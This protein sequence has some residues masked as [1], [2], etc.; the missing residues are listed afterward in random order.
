MRPRAGEAHLQKGQWWH[1]GAARPRI[2]AQTRKLIQTR[3]RVCKR[4][5]PLQA[6]RRVIRA[7]VGFPTDPGLQEEVETMLEL[8]SSLRSDPEKPSYHVMPRN[9]WIN[10]AH[11][12]LQLLALSCSF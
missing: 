6:K 4:N 10:G 5:L 9:G 12:I 11:F 7:C 3:K 1:A 8:A 2:L